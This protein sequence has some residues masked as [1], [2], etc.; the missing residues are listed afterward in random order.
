MSGSN[1]TKELS[2]PFIV[3]K[4]NGSH[5][6]AANPGS[7]CC[8]M[9]VILA[10]A[11]VVL[12]L[13][14]VGYFFVIRND[15][16]EVTAVMKFGTDEKVSKLSNV[17]SFKGSTG[18]TALSSDSKYLAYVTKEKSVIVWDV[19]ANIQLAEF[20]KQNNASDDSVVAFSFINE[21]KDLLLCTYRGF[22]QLWNLETKA[23]TLKH[24]FPYDIKIMKITKDFK[25]ALILVGSSVLVWSF[26]TKIAGQ[27]F[28]ADRLV[29]PDIAL[30]PDNKF[31]AMIDIEGFIKL[32][33]FETAAELEHFEFGQSGSKIQF[34]SDSKYLLSTGYGNKIKVWDI[35]THKQL[36]E[37]QHEDLI[38]TIVLSKDSKYV[39]S[40][41]KDLT[42]RI[43]E[44]ETGKLAGYFKYQDEVVGFDISEGNRYMYLADSA[45]ILKIWNLESKAEVNR[46]NA[47]QSLISVEVSKD[48][49]LV[50]GR[51]Q[52]N[53]VY[54]WK[55]E[56]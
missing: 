13:A 39:V 56:P 14:V 23:E 4:V 37:V 35:S 21:N 19:Q 55:T 17:S 30:S 44:I 48:Q 28:K 29:V 51:G 42:I 27:E 22:L 9:F 32:W 38:G 3:D 34:T 6:K 36:S 5:A 50:L 15:P 45:G 53:T 47:G 46:L 52:D 40:T 12:G 2:A 18:V 49:K 7:S 20:A 41:S 54:L 31:L 43:V 16:N 10:I 11:A 25:R 24:K 8:K 33:N 1:L 26:D